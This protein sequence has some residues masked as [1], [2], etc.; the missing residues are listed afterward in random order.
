MKD[1]AF[2]SGLSLATVD[3][4][5]NERPGVRATTR[6]RVAAA[7]EELER[8]YGAA[9]FAGRRLAIDI[10]MEAPR[11]FSDAVRS[12]FEAEMPGMRPASVAARYHLAERM[13]EGD[14]ASILTAIAKRGSHGVLLKAPSTLATAEHAHRLTAAGIPVATYV[15]DIAPDCRIAYVGMDNRIAG[16][17]AAHL[18]GHMLGGTPAGVLLNLSSASFAGETER[19]A[20]FRDVLTRRFP[21]LTV[22]TVSEGHGV[23]RETFQHVVEALSRNPAL[24]A[25]YSAGGANAAIL[26]AFAHE[27]RPIRVF[28]AHD[29][30]AAN[31]RLLKEGRLTFVIH[32]DFRQDART[33]CQV[34]L[35]H[36]RMLPTQFAAAPS[37]ICIATPYDV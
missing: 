23:H 2:Q 24:T 22:E 8:Q 35:H 16:A 30:D 32:H 6:A 37:Q 15:T 5:L 21:A 17:S 12:A 9:G 11:R 18:M 34:F 27:R 4:V 1:V 13:R 14:L 10:V 26:E 28:A 19:V 36:H 7:V 25:V 33:A 3:R 29:L 31:R 20:G